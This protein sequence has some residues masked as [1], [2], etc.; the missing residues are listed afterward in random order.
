M[1]KIDD[2]TDSQKTT[3]HLG[4]VARDDFMSG[5]GGASGGHSRC[6]WAV[7]PGV[8]LQRL[9]RWV[10]SRPELKYV[11]VVN[12]NSYR[13]PSTTSHYHIYIAGVDHPSQD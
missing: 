11:N 5:W 10:R 6:A 12:L 3:H 7:A 2:R 8:S 13:P 9:E 4:I 1:T